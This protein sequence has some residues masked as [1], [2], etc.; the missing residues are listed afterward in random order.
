M[1]RRLLAVY[2]CC[3][4]YAGADL[5]AHPGRCPIRLLVV[6]SQSIPRSALRLLFLLVVLEGDFELVVDH[7]FCPVRGSLQTM[8]YLQ[9]VRV[10]GGF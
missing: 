2:G 5:F 7:F 6:H 1:N 10:V 4:R 9:V 3:G 8:G